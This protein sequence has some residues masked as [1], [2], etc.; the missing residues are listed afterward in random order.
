M[1]NTRICHSDEKRQ[2]FANWLEDWDAR[3]QTH[4]DYETR[5]MINDRI[6]FCF[7]E[8]NEFLNESERKISEKHLSEEAAGKAL[9]E[10][11]DKAW[12]KKLK[13][14]AEMLSVLDIQVEQL[15][16]LKNRKTHEIFKLRSKLS[17]VI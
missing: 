5:Q 13:K 2:D 14:V 3:I 17:K 15:Y 6:R 8:I 4:D 1:R 16:E 12:Y 9:V 10:H 11:Q 7:T